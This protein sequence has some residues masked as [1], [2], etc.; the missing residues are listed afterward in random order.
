MR[1]C[2][3]DEHEEE[4][5]GWSIKIR[6]SKADDDAASSRR[7]GWHNNHWNDGA[8]SSRRYDCH[9]NHWNGATSNRRDGWHTTAGYGLTM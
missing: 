4:G 1:A 8:A 5:E 6:G 9:N 3:G 7:D 2:Y